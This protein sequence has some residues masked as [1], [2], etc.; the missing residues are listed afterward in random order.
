MAEQKTFFTRR[1]L[2]DLVW[3]KPAETL[4]AEFGM[5]GRGL[6]KLCERH[7]V[8][9]PPRDGEPLREFRQLLLRLAEGKLPRL[10]WGQYL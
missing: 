10:P 5:S 1:E 9:V 7:G 8:P 4:A 6:G 3:K 2:Y